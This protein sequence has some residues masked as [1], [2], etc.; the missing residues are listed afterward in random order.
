MSFNDPSNNEGS[1]HF[2]HLNEFDRNPHSENLLN[3]YRPYFKSLYT[4]KSGDILMPW[5]YIS[6]LFAK[7]LRKNSKRSSVCLL[8]H[9][10]GVEIT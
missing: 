10:C 4:Q 3:W 8:V 5:P 1:P 7:K 2:F 9:M 6:H